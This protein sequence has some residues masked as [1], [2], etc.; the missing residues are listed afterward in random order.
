VENKGPRLLVDAGWPGTLP[1]FIASLKRKGLTLRDLGYVLVTHYHPDHAGL[2]QELK[3][4]GVVH[5]VLEEQRAGMALLKSQVKPGSGY[6]DILLHD[7]LYLSAAQSRAWLKSIGLQ[8]EIV[9]TPGHSDDSIS[10]VLDEGVAFTGDLTLPFA[11]DTDQAKTI[12]N[13]WDLL[14]K[15]KVRSIQPGHGPARP[16]P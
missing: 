4:A 14:R 10:L 7:N 16:I 1:K 9:S 11:E 5:I 12:Q 6:V 8:G 15:L 3:N 13:S 2:V